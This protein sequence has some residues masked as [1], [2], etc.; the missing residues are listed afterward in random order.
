MK[1]F[2]DKDGRRQGFQNLFNLFDEKSLQMLNANKSGLLGEIGKLLQPDIGLY[3]L[4]N[5]PIFMTTVGFAVTG[6]EKS[7]IASLQKDDFVDIG[8][9][10]Y[11][12]G[13]AI[14]QFIASILPLMDF[15]GISGKSTSASVSFPEPKITHNDFYTKALYRNVVEQ[16]HLREVE[17]AP[18]L[19]YVLTQVNVSYLLLP[20][21][22]LPD[23]NLLLRIQFLTAYHATNSLLEIKDSISDELAQLIVSDNIFTKVPNIVSVRNTLAHYGIHKGKIYVSDSIDPLGDVI[24]GYSGMSLNDLRSIVNDELRKLSEWTCSKFS[25]QQLKPIR[26]IFGD[27]T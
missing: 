2:D 5:D 4:D 1:F 14:G 26:A 12:F 8:Q 24:R 18:I 6:M 21:L 22:L 9:K 3:F 25:K 27:H 17:L 23:S 16:S 11:T 19:F 15:Y 13:N 20:R 10:S 7:E